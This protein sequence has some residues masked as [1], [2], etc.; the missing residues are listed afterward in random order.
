MGNQQVFR[1]R[2]ETGAF[3]V[4]EL[5]FVIEGVFSKFLHRQPGV[6]I[7]FAIEEASRE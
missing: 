6:R 2:G 3:T 7:L 5:L 4:P 1:R